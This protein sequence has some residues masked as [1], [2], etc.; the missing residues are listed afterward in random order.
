MD[1]PSIAVEELSIG[2]FLTLAAA[3]VFFVMIMIIMLK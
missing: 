2:Y 3:Y 1:G